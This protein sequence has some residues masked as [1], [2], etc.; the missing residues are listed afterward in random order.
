ML[1]NPTLEL[2]VQLK[3]EKTLGVTPKLKPIKEIVDIDYNKKG[4]PN[5]TIM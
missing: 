4:L 3:M 2:D 1:L 5:T